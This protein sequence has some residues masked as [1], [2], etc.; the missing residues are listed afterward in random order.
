[1]GFNPEIA[2]D[3]LEAGAIAAGLSG[4]GPSFVSIT[5]EEKQDDIIDAWDS[6]PGDIIIT[7]VDNQGTQFR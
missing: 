5:R 3:A 2:V 6:Y 1:M 7:G 4:T